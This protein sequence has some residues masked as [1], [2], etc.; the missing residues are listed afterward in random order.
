MN[1]YER[2]IVKQVTAVLEEREVLDPS[3]FGAVAGATA[4]SS[5]ASS[6]GASSSSAPLA[7]APA[8]ALQSFDYSACPAG[9]GTFFLDNHPSYNPRVQGQVALGE[10]FDVGQGIAVRLGQCPCGALVCSRCKALVD[11]RQAHTHVCKNATAEIDS[12]TKA[13]ITKI[14]KACPAC[15]M[16]IE[17]NQGCSTM[18]CGT[19]AHGQISEALR[20]GGCAH[21]FD[22]NSLRPLKNGR[23][24][25]PFN[26]RQ[27]N[28]RT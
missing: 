21:E 7:P 12:A 18:M 13:L 2:I 4:S 3:Q 28:F 23:P 26:D 6:A 1:K 22:W 10:F 20:N 17:K 24:G 14:G 9:C 5:N 19:R 8:P 27:K 25:A 15:G 16:L 11:H